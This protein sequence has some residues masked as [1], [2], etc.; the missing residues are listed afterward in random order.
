MPRRTR[1]AVVLVNADHGPGRHS[2]GSAA[3]VVSV[4]ELPASSFSTVDP[5]PMIITQSA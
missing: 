2:T 3:S 1:V 5:A 4:I